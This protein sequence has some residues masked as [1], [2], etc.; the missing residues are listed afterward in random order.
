MKRIVALAVATLFLTGCGTTVDPG[1][2]GIRVNYY[3]SNRGVDDYPLVTGRVWYNPWTTTV[4]SYPVYVQTAKWTRSMDEGKKANEEISFNSKEGMIW[5]ADISLSYH[6]DPAKVPHF[7]V[8]FRSDD[9]DSFTHGYLRNVARDAFNDTTVLYSVDDI[10]SGKREEMLI[11]IKERIAREVGQY[12]VILDQFGFIGTPRPPEQVATAI[13]NKIQATQRA[14]Q[15]ENEV[16]QIRA[17]A[18]KAVAAA[19]GRAKSVLVEAEAQAKA[20]VMVS[21]SLTPQLLTNSAIA[22]WNGVQ[23]LYMGGGGGVLFNIPTGKQ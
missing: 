14:L 6:L 11:K 7:Y 1:H 20:N 8:K 2:V 13:N 22:K 19:E 16:Q 9:L 3:G 17:E 4:L 15:A 10:Y 18:Q 12:G 23:P 21:Q 5:T